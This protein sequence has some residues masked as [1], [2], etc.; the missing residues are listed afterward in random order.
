[1]EDGNALPKSKVAT[2]AR[3]EGEAP[4]DAKLVKTPQE[5]ESTKAPQEDRL[6]TGARQDETRYQS[7]KP[8]AVAPTAQSREQVGSSRVINQ[9]IKIEQ[10]DQSTEITEQVSNAPQKPDMSSPARHDSAPRSATKSIVPDTELGL[11]Q[12]NNQRLAPLTTFSLNG[13]IPRKRKRPSRSRGV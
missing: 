5:A 8:K 7:I 12:N 10:E 2:D 11:A 9:D 1:M 6:A 4:R 3:H 13:L